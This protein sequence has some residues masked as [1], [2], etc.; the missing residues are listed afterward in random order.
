MCILCIAYGRSLMGSL[1]MP[2]YFYIIHTLLASRLT[3][4]HFTTSLDYRRRAAGALPQ[5]ERPC[6]V[7]SLP[8]LEW[9]DTGSS[10]VADLGAV[11]LVLASF[12]PMDIGELGVRYCKLRR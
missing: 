9:I 7:R 12:P 4:Q 2:Q 1:L 11:V 10:D 5:T 8:T 3:G 6:S